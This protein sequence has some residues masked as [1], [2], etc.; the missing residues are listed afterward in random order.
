MGLLTKFRLKILS[1]VLFVISTIS[2]SLTSLLA[3][4]M[5][6]APPEQMMSGSGPGQSGI[7]TILLAE[8]GFLVT[9]IVI[10]IYSLTRE[11]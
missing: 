7:S 5:T 10:Y 11:E 3:T 6:Y 1:I 9:S 4:Q 2:I 8:I